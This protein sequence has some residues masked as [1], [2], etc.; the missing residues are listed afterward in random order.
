MKRQGLL[1]ATGI[2]LLGL[3]M[4]MTLH[5]WDDSLPGQDLAVETAPAILATGVT[6]R[7]FSEK[8][9]QLQYHLTADDLVQYDHNPLT[10]MKNPALEMS[11]DKGSWTI[12]GADGTVQNNGDMIIFAGDVKARNPQQKIELDTQ[13]LRFNSEENIATS[14]G[15]VELRFENG[16]THA[17]ALEADLDK[18][19]LS[20]EQGVKSEFDAPA[21]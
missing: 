15:E 11:N 1:S 13:E 21:S 4:L 17:G 2:L 10:E 8:D 20:L 9:G 12:T 7:A 19:I 14:P 6:A 18:G 3:V 5:E 16:Q